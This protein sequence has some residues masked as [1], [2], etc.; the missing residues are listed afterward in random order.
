M[1]T[2]TKLNQLFNGISQVDVI[3]LAILPDAGV[4]ATAI[5]GVT[6]TNGMYVIA[7]LGTSTG[8]TPNANSEGIYLITINGANYTLGSVVISL[9][10]TSTYNNG[11]PTNFLVTQGTNLGSYQWFID[12]N[13]AVNF[14]INGIQEITSTDNSVIITNPNGPTVNLQV[15]GGGITGNLSYILMTGYNVSNVENGPLSLTNVARTSKSTDINVINTN[16]NLPKN[17]TFPNGQIKL[18]LDLSYYTPTSYN[19]YGINYHNGLFVA[20]GDN[21]TILSSSDGF[22][23]SSHNVV[24][25]VNFKDVAST[26]SGFWVAVGDNG[27]IYTSNDG[28]TWTAQTSGTTENL[29]SIAIADNNA[30]IAV[31]TNGT[32]VKSL[33]GTTW[34]VLTPISA[35]NFLKIGV[36]PE[37]LTLSRLFVALGAT[38][39]IYTSSNDGV[40]WT[41]Q[42]SGTTT[43]L[44]GFTYNTVKNQLIIT[45]DNGTILTS[46]DGTTW[47]AQTSGV[48]NNLNSIVLDGTGKY[49]ISGTNG[50]ILTSYDATNWEIGQIDL[51]YYLIRDLAI[52]FNNNNLIIGIGDLGAILTSYGAIN[53]SRLPASAQFNVTGINCNVV[54]EIIEVSGSQVNKQILINFTITTTNLDNPSVNITASNVLGSI[55]I[56]NSSSICISNAAGNTIINESDMTPIDFFTITPVGTYSGVKTLSPLNGV[57]SSYTTGDND[58][59]LLL[60]ET[61]ASACGLYLTSSTGAWTKTQ[62]FDSI[63]SGSAFLVENDQFATQ[64]WY[65]PK[66][67]FVSNAYYLKPSNGILM[68]KYIELNTNIASLSGLPTLNGTTLIDGDLVYLNNQNTASQNGLYRAGL[69]AWYKL[70]EPEELQSTSLT[71]FG[72]V[73]NTLGVRGN[74]Y[75]IQPYNGSETNYTLFGTKEPFSNQYRVIDYL[76]PHIYHS[77]IYDGYPSFVDALYALG[78]GDPASIH[79]LN[80]PGNQ[81]TGYYNEKIGT[82]SNLIYGGNWYFNYNVSKGLNIDAVINDGWVN[83]TFFDPLFGTNNIDADGAI[84]V[85]RSTTGPWNIANYASIY[86]YNPVLG[87]GNAT[88]AIVFKNTLEKEDYVPID[89]N[90]CEL[91]S[92]VD[93]QYG[94]PDISFINPVS[95]QNPINITFGNLDDTKISTNAK[96]FISG[97]YNLYQALTITHHS[98]YMRFSNS[99]LYNTTYNTDA[100]VSTIAEVNF[101]NTHLDSSSTINNTNSSTYLAGYGITS[102]DFDVT[103]FNSGINLSPENQK[104]NTI[105]PTGTSPFLYTAPPGFGT[106]ITDNNTDY[107]GVVTIN[108]GGA[109]ICGNNRMIYNHIGNGLIY[110]LVI[111]PPPGW[112]FVGFDAYLLAAFDVFHFII[113]VVKGTNVVFRFNWEGKKIYIE[114][115]NFPQT[116]LKLGLAGKTFTTGASNQAFPVVSSAAGFKSILPTSNA[117]SFNNSTGNITPPPGRYFNCVVTIYYTLSSTSTANTRININSTGSNLLIKGQSNEYLL[118]ND[119]GSG[120]FITQAQITFDVY[121]LPG[122]VNAEVSNLYLTVDVGANDTFITRNNGKIELFPLDSTGL[123]STSGIN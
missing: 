42:I 23:W 51:G 30:M 119:D 15:S 13:N 34:S 62:S 104:I 122:A 10:N 32:V 102:M 113:G 59:V 84:T 112:T 83:T 75:T 25:T 53:W 65:K 43:S 8:G 115:V 45:G 73:D 24:S 14:K 48:P 55:S 114:Q 44:R 105:T 103:P 66:S 70:A 4:A 46:N 58:V 98:G 74:I 56:L 80:T 35:D 100:G 90:G 31:G 97:L 36:T 9:N 40:S 81:L 101:F 120:T 96:M 111:V 60:W 22:T 64:I 7:T 99:Q 106:I 61:P 21:G 93:V 28:T 110:S 87:K 17:I 77:S 94:N 18:N 116:S 71:M 107:T 37:R 38:G 82:D 89:L 5:P 47:T 1:A 95:Y 88:P 121:T 69:N 86:L 39:E 6:L 52:N 117:F 109:G 27:I 57:G 79:V 2:N 11:Q 123:V 19:L 108:L 72:G 49:I 67:I 12:I 85:T 33:D 50:I 68:V 78:G 91:V 29:L 76:A 26:F 54:S 3:A 16:I 20:V 118:I 63:P 41:S 92:D